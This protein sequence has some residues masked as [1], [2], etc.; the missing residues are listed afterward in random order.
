MFVGSYFDPLIKGMVFGITMAAIPG[1]IF[2]LI[3]QRTIMEGEMVGFFCGLGSIIADAFY[4]LLA[5]IG[6]SYIMDFLITYQSIFAFLGSIFLLYLGYSIFKRAPLTKNFELQD[7]SLLAA[8][9]STFFLTISNPVT[10]FSYCV[11]FASLGIDGTNHHWYSTILLL[12]GVVI[13]SLFFV[14][15]FIGF[16]HYFKNIVSYRYIV[17]FNKIIGVI[18][19]G[20]ALFAFIKSFSPILP[21]CSIKQLL[22]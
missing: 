15:F 11:I 17:I 10:I 13:G 3:M 9:V 19:M 20:F 18:L 8:L 22:L 12:T 5:A 21:D 4:A 1:P 16:L 6:L 14:L 7:K 2:F